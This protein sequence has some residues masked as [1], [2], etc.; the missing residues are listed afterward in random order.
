MVCAKGGVDMSRISLHSELSDILSMRRDALEDTCLVKGANDRVDGLTLFCRELLRASTVCYVDGEICSYS[1]GYYEVLGMD[2][3]RSVLVELLVDN[4]VSPLD[5]RRMGDMPLGVIGEREY[6]SG[7]TLCFDNGVLDLVS[8]RFMGFS[9]DLHVRRR[10]EYSYSSEADCPRWEAF[11]SEVIPDFG[12]RRALQ[13]FFGMVFLDRQRYS[14]EKMA[15][16]VG[17]GA[18]GKSVIFEVM[19]RV[20]G[21]DNV[22]MLD[23]LQ[24]TDEKM[25][26]SVQGK[27]LNFAPDL[28]RHRDFSSALKALASGQDVTG[29]KIYGE[30]EKVKCPPLVFAM[31]DVPVIRDMSD[32]F[33]RRVLYFGFDVQIPPERQDKSLVG[34]ICRTDL[35]GIFCWIIAGRDR[36]I[37]QGGEFSR[38]DKMAAD[39]R[40]LRIRAGVEVAPVRVWMQSQG[41]SVAPS[42][43]GQGYELVSCAQIAAA[44]GGSVSLNAIAREVSGLGAA[45]VRN[46]ETYY[47]FY[48]I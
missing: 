11:L 44:L 33:F 3:V 7:G 17:R 6:E 46:R 28:A 1:G 43:D 13:E 16:F 19:K 12:E 35:P 34:R 29:R 18:N 31:N 47:K 5:V 20:L 30:A 38:S 24:L 48:R 21:E 39:L 40:G 37:R 25:I 23:S 45:R 14:V 36:L 8:G 27:L 41:L 42:Y 4:G 15:F 2:N 26:P 22:T 9:P 32:A 10:V